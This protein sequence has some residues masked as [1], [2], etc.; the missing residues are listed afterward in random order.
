MGA[1][2]SSGICSQLLR[3]TLQTTSDSGDHIDKALLLD[4]RILEQVI[5][6]LHEEGWMRHKEKCREASK[7]EQTGWSRMLQ[8]LGRLDHPVHSA[9]EASRHFLYVAATLLL[10]EG[11]SP[12][13]TLGNLFVR[14][15]GKPL[16]GKHRK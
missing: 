11:N 2:Q 10:E 12:L 13:Q 5:P 14:L 6:L 16:R 1:N 4:D 9:N 15:L 8:A 3:G 7:L